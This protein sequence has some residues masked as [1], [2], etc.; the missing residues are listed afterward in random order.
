MAGALALFGVLSVRRAGATDCAPAAVVEGPAAIAGPVRAI[1]QAHGVASSAAEC[2][3]KVVRAS[4]LSESG[5]A[6]YTLHIVDAFGRSSVRQVADAETAASLIESWAV[7]G[8]GAPATV[9]PPAAAVSSGLT[10]AEGDQLPPWRLAGAVE[11]SAGTDSSF[12]YGGSLTG[13]GRVAGECLGARVRLARDEGT[14]EPPGDQGS[15]KRTAIE[16]LAIASVSLVSGRF[17]F[18]PAMGL[19][20]TWTHT[21]ALLPGNDVDMPVVGDAI[22]LRL[23]AAASFGL[24]ISRR[25]W[26]VGDVS[27]SLGR[28]LSSS[29]TAGA[30]RVIGNPPP[31][32]LRIGM[33]CQYAP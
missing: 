3:E 11:L 29:N 1:L 2:P 19:G 9:G 24:A 16:L 20:P 17:A 27:A 6:S 5:S 8:P 33:G 28:S 22:G 10:L 14:G 31:G 18:T 26:L 4:L 21:R 12:W 23:E 13:C 25:F 30:D 32:Y 7:P 15:G